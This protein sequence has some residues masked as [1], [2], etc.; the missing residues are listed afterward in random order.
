MVFVQFSEDYIRDAT[1]VWLKDYVVEG[2]QYILSFAEPYVTKRVVINLSYGP[3]TGPHDGMAQL[4][5]ALTALVA[6]LRWN[7]WE[8]QARDLPRGG[9]FLSHRGPRRLPQAP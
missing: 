6:R 8:T 7:Q 1:G 2:I 9:Q 4:E 3:T 5:K